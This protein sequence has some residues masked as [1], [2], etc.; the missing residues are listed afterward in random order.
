MDAAVA[1][2]GPKDKSAGKPGQSAKA[3]VEKKIVKAKK[4]VG[5]AVAAGAVTAPKAE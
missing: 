4:R 3:G 5:T 1:V 2:A